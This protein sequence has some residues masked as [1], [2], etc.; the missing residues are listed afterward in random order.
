[1]LVVRT[2]RALE[3]FANDQGGSTIF[4]KDATKFT[5]RRGDFLQLGIMSEALNPMPYTLSHKP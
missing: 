5:P 4:T 1:M 3:L 2:L